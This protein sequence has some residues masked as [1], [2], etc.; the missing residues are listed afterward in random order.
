ML[1]LQTKDSKRSDSFGNQR[2][3]IEYE[4]IKENGV[5]TNVL[6][7][8]DRQ[9]YIDL[10]A[11]SDVIIDFHIQEDKI[12]TVTTFFKDIPIEYIEN[13]F[14]EMYGDRNWEGFYFTED[15]QY[16]TTVTLEKGMASTTRWES[17]PF[18]V[19]RYTWG[20]VR[21][22]QEKYKKEHSKD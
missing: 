19:G 14:D 8:R 16:F 11:I 7:Y 12:Y 13:R 21:Q 17:T 20:N 9:F 1:E 15:F 10:K 6:V 2:I 18:N 3:P 4:V 22:M 5:T